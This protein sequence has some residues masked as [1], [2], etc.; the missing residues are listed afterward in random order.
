MAK[1]RACLGSSLPACKKDQQ[2]DGKDHQRCGRA[3]RH[4]TVSQGTVGHWP[5]AGGRGA[6][7]N[8]GR[9]WLMGQLVRRHVW[10]G[11]VMR[12]RRCG[13]VGRRGVGHDRRCK[14][15]MGKP[16]GMARIT[17]RTDT[18]KGQ[19]ACKDCHIKAQTELL[20]AREGAG[21]GAFSSAGVSREPG[22]LH[23]A[24]YTI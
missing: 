8:N 14:D 4:T 10:P 11:G 15:K 3:T 12:L 7:D 24:Y 23:R 17:Q 5:C 6:L 19:H 20:P 21:Q 22:A 18:D 1:M 2:Q 13:S 16:M 9:R